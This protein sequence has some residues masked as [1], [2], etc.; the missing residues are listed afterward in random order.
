MVVRED[1]AGGRFVAAPLL[2]HRDEASDGRHLPSLFDSSVISGLTIPDLQ[3]GRRPPEAAA[4]I[5]LRASSLPRARR[6]A[7]PKSVESMQVTLT[8]GPFAHD[9]WSFEPKLDGVRAIAR[10]SDSG[11]ATT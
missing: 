4:P 2:K 1:P 9:D 6:I 10:L 11:V 7:T 5:P 3:A 8:A